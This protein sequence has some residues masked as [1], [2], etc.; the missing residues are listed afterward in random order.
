MLPLNR[1]GV[2]AFEALLSGGILSRTIVNLAPGG[3]FAT[4]WLDVSNY[5]PVRVCSLSNVASAVGGVV[6]EWSMDGVTVHAAEAPGS[7][8]AGVLYDSTNIARRMPFLRVTYT[9]G[10]VVQAT[11][12]FVVCGYSGGGGGGGGVPLTNVDVQGNIWTRPEPDPA[13]IEGPLADFPLQGEPD[14]CL[15]TRGAV[16]T[17]E[18]AHSDDFT[19]AAAV[20]D[21][22][23]LGRYLTGVCTIATGGVIVTGTVGTLFTSEVKAGDY[24]CLQPDWVAATPPLVQVLAV[25]SDTSLLLAAAYA[26]A[27]GSFVGVV[28]DYYS[29]EVGTGTL[30]RVDVAGHSVCDFEVHDDADGDRA[31]LWRRAG[32]MLRKATLP[33]RHAFRMSV[34]GL[35]ENLRAYVGIGE[36]NLYANV[37]EAFGGGP[38]AVGGSPFATGVGPRGVAVD[39]L[40][41]VWIVNSGGNTVS[42]FDA[43]THIEVGGSPFATGLG[44]AKVAV[45]ALGQVW[46]TN[47][48]GNS[49]SVFNAATHLQ[50]LGSPFATGVAPVGVD[51][52]ALGRVWVA[53]N[54]DN[55]VTVF[56][57]A[58]HAPVV[59]S[60][61]PTGVG[62]YGLKVDNIGQCWIVNTGA[63]TLTVYDVASLIEVIGSPFATAGTPRFIVA[64]LYGRV[65]VTNAAGNS[66]TVYD[67]ATH[68]EVG[69]SPFPTGVG[70]NG[71]AIDAL[72][73]IWITNW[74]A[75]TVTVYDTA[76]CTEIAGSP[77]AT[78]D[79]PANVAVDALGQIWITDYDDDD[80]TV[81]L[82]YNGVLPTACS[83]A[84]FEFVQTQASWQYTI[85]TA[86]TLAANDR[87][88]ELLTAPT[89]LSGWHTFEIILHWDHCDFLLDGVLL[90]SVTD[91]LPNVYED[92]GEFCIAAGDANGQGGNHLS[93]DLDWWRLRSMDVLD[94]EEIDAASGMALRGETWSKPAPHPQAIQGPT[95]ATPLQFE[96]DGALRNRGTALT[97]EESYNDDFGNT[98]PAT[99]LARA[100]T[101]TSQF[102]TG[103]AAVVGTGTL[104]ETEVRVGDYVYLAADT[105]T[106]AAQV[107]SIPDNTHL[108]L[109]AVYGGAGGAA[110]ASSVVNWR[111]TGMTFPPTLNASDCVFSVIGGVAGDYGQIERSLGAGS[112]KPSLPARFAWRGAIT[113]PHN[114]AWTLFGLIDPGATAY[115]RFST[116]GVAVATT[117]L[118]CEVRGDIALQQTVTIPASG[119]F[120]NKHLYEILLSAD[121][122]VFL[123]DGAEVATLRYHMPFPYTGL[124][125]YTRLEFTADWQGHTAV[126]T[127]DEIRVRSLNLLDVQ[128]EK[129]LLELQT[130]TAA[131]AS[132]EGPL[133]T[134]VQNHAINDNTVHP[135]AVALVPNIPYLLQISGGEGVCY[136]LTNV[137]APASIQTLPY[138]ISGQ[139]RQ[140]RTTLV[141]VIVYLQKRVN[142]TADA[143]GILVRD[144]GL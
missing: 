64:D 18:G 40:G 65:W 142:G 102:T 3:A 117:Q 87:H 39:A 73:Q 89:N 98:A 127:I 36:Y 135:F 100:L 48:G 43:A 96:P 118:I 128:D 137:G 131:L 85:N 7:A 129:A 63:N 13:S 22:I 23:Q 74:T 27:G 29:T 115:A 16:M 91:H 38:V 107:A 24:F 130:L 90:A 31:T 14:G 69:G 92:M 10:A 56:D 126:T 121:A 88:T 95:V 120:T 71:I 51:V 78:G 80:V 57:A 61:F 11:F 52:D 103:L 82:T 2:H 94:E 32:G 30:T 41:Q 113:T 84:W 83:G 28:Q 19:P 106:A 45:D 17:D 122:A 116:T 76:T 136:A 68:V 62:P 4:P 12:L 70:P 97:D 5:D 47:Q 58:T 139:S 109:R 46:V 6:M 132:G 33:L 134:S 15:R 67:A 34:S 53:N 124:M 111:T 141:G 50:V 37:A 20:G 110:G 93:L 66:V 49:V 35:D 104:Y 81:F 79:D 55:T 26:G 9:N 21:P 144:D 143:T 138:L 112:R 1:Y 108:T 59:G 42:V 25:L 140:L 8:L 123:I 99:P 75:H 125:A 101:G 44:P 77:F 133:D 105:Y 72:G 54:N 114:N 86:P 60:P 119:V